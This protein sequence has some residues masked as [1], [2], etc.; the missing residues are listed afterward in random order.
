MTAASTPHDVNA[1]RPPAR[2]RQRP[3]RRQRPRQQPPRQQPPRQPPPR[4]PP[5]LAPPV[6]PSPGPPCRAAWT[7][8]PL[9]CVP[10]GS[11]EDQ[12]APIG[13]DG[14]VE[15]AAQVVNNGP[16]VSDATVVVTL[17]AG[18]RLESD[19]DD[20]VNRY[21]DWWSADSDD[22]G[23]ALACTSTVDGSSVTCNTGSVPAGANFLVVVDLEAQDDAVAGTSGIFT[24]GLESTPT[25]GDLS[26][27]IG[28]GNGRLCRHRASPGTPHARQ[29]HGRGRQDPDA[30]RHGP[31]PRTE[32][33]R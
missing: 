19:E 21:E 16:A 5:R 6:T 30:H 24:V 15:F 29:G 7:L 8:T 17:P 20:P 25:P 1:P 23:T 12:P 32:R 14:F 26:D 9:L 13:T 27:H 33:R 2:R 28:R 31:Q 11:G 10:T 3:P 18:L 22:E 4:Q